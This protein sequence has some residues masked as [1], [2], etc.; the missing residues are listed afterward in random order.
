MKRI[1]F[2]MLLAVVSAFCFAE[3]LTVYVEPGEI[4]AKRA[5]QLAVWLE[6]EDGAFV[7]TL[8]VTKS[9]SKKSWIASPKEGR[10]ESLPDW[11]KASGV[12]PA[13]KTVEGL[14]AYTGATPKKGITFCRQVA[15]E[16]GLNYVVK[17]QI[18]QS[19]DYNDYY[20][21]KNSGVD[22]QPAVLYAGKILKDSE[23][24][25]KIVSDL[26]KITT[27]DRISGKIYVDVR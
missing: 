23:I 7:E 17:A 16:D 12:N 2:I 9:A 10:P 25:L 3:S 20:T 4:W 6:T 8:F 27:A 19:F 1:T 15:L 18:N 5:P 11:Y 24:E 22:G 21:K 26:E 14:D 13:K